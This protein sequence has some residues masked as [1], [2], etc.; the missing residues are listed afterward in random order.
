MKKVLLIAFCSIFILNNSF[1]QKVVNE[2]R[3]SYKISIE[4]S[5]DNAAI[6]KSL[7]GATFTVF[8]KGTASR[9]EMQSSLGTESNIYDSKSGKGYILKEYSGQK[10]MITMNKDN[11]SEKNQLF[12]NL[13]FN[14]DN[15]EETVAGYTSKKATASMENGDPFVVYYLSDIIVSNKDY[16]NAF[17]N[18]GGI[19]VQ[20]E[21]QSG[22][23]KF[24]YTLTDINYDFIPAAKFDIP[25][26][27]FRVMTY[28]ENRQLKKG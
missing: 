11:W 21:L 13:K 17:R 22:K 16:N 6:S 7:D 9:S 4:S 1:S 5:K 18:L 20:Y 28:D 2:L 14:I 27:G 26:A 23:L 8:I 12:Q 24:K 10:L 15:T 19:P 3:L 25:K